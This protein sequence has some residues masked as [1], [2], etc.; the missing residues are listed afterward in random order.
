M[1]LFLVAPRGTN[2]VNWNLV[3]RHVFEFN[4]LVYGNEVEELCIISLVCIELVLLIAVPVLSKSSVD[5]VFADRIIVGP[6]A[7]LGM[8]RAH[9]PT[10][11][12]FVIA[13]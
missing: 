5:R 7:A 13:K 10:K 2:C 1:V 12:C 9:P 8:Y 11:L 6:K 4:V 3:R